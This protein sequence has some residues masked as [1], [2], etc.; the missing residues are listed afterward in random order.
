MPSAVFET[1]IITYRV[2]TPSAARHA[3]AILSLF[4]VSTQQIIVL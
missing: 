2:D 1:A 4:F 3:F